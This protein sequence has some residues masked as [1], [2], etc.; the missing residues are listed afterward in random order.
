MRWFNNLKIFHKLLISF[1][2]FGLILFTQ[3]YLG[4]S[5]VAHMSVLSKQLYHDNFV[6][7]EKLLGMVEKLN[8]TRALL[9]QHIHAYEMKEFTE[10]EKHMDDYYSQF[11][12]TLQHPELLCLTT[13][14]QQQLFDKVFKDFQLTTE[15]DKKVIGLSKEF[16]KEEALSVLTQKGQSTFRTLLTGIQELLS[17]KS[18]IAQ[19]SYQETLEIQKSN[20]I[21]LIFILTI[22]V[23]VLLIVVFTLSRTINHPLN[24]AVTLANQLAKGDLTAKIHV[25][26]QD[27]PGQLLKAMQA[28][29]ED[30]HCMMSQ[31]VES[32]SHIALLSSQLVSSSHKLSQGASEQVAMSDETY[33]CLRKM[34]SSSQSVETHTQT[35]ANNIN[36]TSAAVEQMVSSVQSIADSISHL[37]GAVEEA[38]TFMEQIGMTVDQV[39]F[40]SRKVNEASQ[41]TLKEAQEGGL[42]VK[43]T[44][45][46]MKE[47]S[48]MVD[49]IYFVIHKFEESSRKMG[50]I[51][52]VIGDIARQ[53]HLLAVNAAIEAARA[54]VHGRGFSVVAQEVRHLAI[55]SS[56]F[57]EEVTQLLE[58]IQMGIHEA[59]DTTQQTV[60]K[61][62]QGVA[63]S[64]EAGHRLDKIVDMIGTVNDMMVKISRATVQQD[65]ASNE[66]VKKVEKM[67]VMTKQVD[68]ASKEQAIGSQQILEAIGII[69]TMMIEVSQATYTQREHGQHVIELLEN[70]TQVSTHHQH[71]ATQLLQVTEELNH[72]ADTLRQMTSFFKVS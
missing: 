38:T 23:M 4:L 39:A 10:I 52:E 44:I 51:I 46:S 12:T 24:L 62:Q 69:N 56:E 32:S 25:V 41:S 36:G 72:Q 30:M 11:K 19:Q 7:V 16:S 43:K 45:K 64:E 53:T 2:V 27:E 58:G 8:T 60:P 47:I 18:N 5:S 66:C 6:P 13:L 26:Y 31:I 57:I 14:Q 3:G 1:L 54:G 35:L 59:I 50:S 29:I 55:R 9:F 42:A 70:V 17:I 37:Y 61:V 40:N 68:E 15:V 34:V 63:L 33:D 65:E 21:T 67:T 71:I 28:L 49:N 22:S 20:I 48:Q